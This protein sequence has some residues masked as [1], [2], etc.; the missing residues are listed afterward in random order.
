MKNIEIERKWMVKGWPNNLELLYT[1]K[2]RQ[3]YISTSPTVR[4]RDEDSKYILCFKSKGKLSRKEIEM[5]IPKDKFDELEDLI[6]LPLIDKVRKT[7][8]LSDGHHLEVNLVDKGTS[9]EFYYAEVEFS[10]EEEA[11]AFNPNDVGLA[12]YLDDEVT[13]QK[14]QSMAADWIETRGNKL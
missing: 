5:E 7:Y 9:T 3:G 4:I 10:N 6:G 1:E 13:Y 2:M 14:G 8:L 12:D 11:L